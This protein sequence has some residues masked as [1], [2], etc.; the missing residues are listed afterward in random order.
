MFNWFRRNEKAK[1]KDSQPS[2][3]ETKPE[4]DSQTAADSETIT[5]AEPDYL[6]FAKAA[7]QNIQQ[8]QAETEQKEVEPAEAASSEEA[9]TEAGTE[10][11]ATVKQLP[12]LFFATANAFTL[13]AVKSCPAPAFRYNSPVSWD[14]RQL[15]SSLS[16]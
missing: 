7:Y 4:V 9:E 8:R 11:T 1:Q 10:T 14:A 15:V 3:P 12:L 16:R 6:A 2:T 5:S 13:T